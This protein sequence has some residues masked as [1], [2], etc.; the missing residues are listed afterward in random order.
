[1]S[2]GLILSKQNHL[3]FLIKSSQRVFFL[4]LFWEWRICAVVMLLCVNTMCEESARMCFRSSGQNIPRRFRR[5]APTSRSWCP[6][7]T[8]QTMDELDLVRLVC[9]CC[10]RRRRTNSSKQKHTLNLNRYFF[11]TADLSNV[12]RAAENR[13]I[14]K[15]I[16][17]FK[18]V[19]TLFCKIKITRFRS[20]NK[21]DWRF[22]SSTLFGSPLVHRKLSLRCRRGASPNFQEK[23]MTSWKSF[24]GR[25]VIPGG[26]KA[27]SWSDPEASSA[28]GQWR[29][30]SFLHRQLKA[31]E[32]E[33]DDR[34]PMFSEALL[35]FGNKTSRLLIKFIFS[36]VVY[37]GGGCNYII[38]NFGG[39]VY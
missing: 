27:Q 24:I 9:C 26:V 35:L 22:F 1:M 19:V 33:A 29:H 32:V 36:S 31:L 13:E 17:Y 16:F 21:N 37:I 25:F 4:S 39:F 5:R 12:G 7:V 3:V 34:P 28:P 23:T 2:L 10:C 14:L 30:D 38:I 11:P 15:T 18:D 8:C 6:P 20:N